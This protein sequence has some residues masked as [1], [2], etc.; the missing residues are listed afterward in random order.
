[1]P[2][3]L[4]WIAAALALACAAFLGLGLRGDPG[5]A[6]SLRAPRLAALLL[7]GAAIGCAT[8][9]FQ[10]IAG[11]RIL[12]P[13]IMGFDA[14]FGLLQTGLVFALGGFG[15]ATMAPQLRFA[16]EAG[17]LMGGALLLFGTLLGGRRVDLHR[18][19]LTGIVCGVL[20]RS[21]SGFVARMI[22]PNEY[23]IV[24]GSSFARFNAVPIELIAI[25]ALLS[26]LALAV[27]WRLRHR[28]DVMALGRDHAVSLGV[29][30]RRTLMLALAT[31]A[32]LVSVSTAL[33]GPVTFF[34]LLVSAL[35]HLAMRDHRHAVLM[36]A[37]ALIAGLVLVAGQTVIERL[38][39]W[40]LTLSVI[41]EFAGGL[42]FL[43]L[44]LRR[45]A[46]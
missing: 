31:I 2:A 43:V 44:I 14:L 46:P 11:N 27:A 41:V 33:V 8:V 16:L 38:L 40:S 37:A 25:A 10:T 20:F 24:Q 17:L 4:V 9:M 39:G 30:H 7:V 1:M 13:S 28:L 42:L 23:A 32:A 19:I 29:D 6:L 5:F 45:P 3:R 26:L 22:D 15:V 34:G 18:M 12:T 21:L 36:P 35:A